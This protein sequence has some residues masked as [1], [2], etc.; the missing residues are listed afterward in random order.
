MLAHARSGKNIVVSTGMATLQE[1]EAAL[2][3]L[4]F[5]FL[6]LENP[7]LV[8]FQRAFKSD[9]GQAILKEKVT[10]LHC[11]SEYPTPMQHVNLRAMD[12]LQQVFGLSVGYS[13]HTEGLVVPIAAVARGATLIEKHFTLDRSQQGPDH[14]VSLEPNELKEMV[15]AIRAVELALGSHSKTPQTIEMA[16]REVA[17]K[18]LVAA[19]NILAGDCYSV[20][21]LASKRPGTG[22]SPMEYW[23]LLGQPSQRSYLID[24]M[25]E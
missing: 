24:E 1:I 2:G 25:I 3:V 21:N 18:S 19:S 5:G 17:R 16:N 10:L 20:E 12:V 22:L 9:E 13:D 14:Q 4:A 23:R 6:L 11:T 8:A 15:A 7:S